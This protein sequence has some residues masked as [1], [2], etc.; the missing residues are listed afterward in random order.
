VRR[1]IQFRW[2]LGLNFNNERAIS[3]LQNLLE[4]L[5]FLPIASMLQVNGREIFLK[6]REEAATARTGNGTHEAFGKPKV[7]KEAEQSLAATGAVDKHGDCELK[8][9][10]TQAI[11]LR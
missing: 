10:Q 11:P 1:D 2:N 4:P 6:K 3:T 7:S 9:S 8:D 5:E